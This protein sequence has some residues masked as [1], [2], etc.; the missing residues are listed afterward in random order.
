MTMPTVKANTFQ[1]KDNFLNF[2]LFF[3][4]GCEPK[5][6]IELPLSVCFL[7]GNR[8]DPYNRLIEGP[9]IQF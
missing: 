3:V 2:D 4:L 7:F 9:R 5:G 1:T 8:R 6:P